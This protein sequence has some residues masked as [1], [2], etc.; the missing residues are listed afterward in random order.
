MEEN[1]NEETTCRLNL[2]SQVSEPGPEISEYEQNDP[3][4]G[5]V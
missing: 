3:K 5:G 2:F 4:K 1:R